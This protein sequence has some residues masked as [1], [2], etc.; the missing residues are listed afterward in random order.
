MPFCPVILTSNKNNL[1][2]LLWI[3]K[4]SYSINEFC[5]HWNKQNKEVKIYVFWKS[6]ECKLTNPRRKYNHTKDV[7]P[8]CYF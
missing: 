3:Y 6:D 2:T 5:V 7:D 1:T 8:K 4:I